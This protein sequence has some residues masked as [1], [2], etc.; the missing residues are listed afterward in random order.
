MQTIS[1]FDIRVALSTGSR[2]TLES[3][4]GSTL[5]SFKVLSGIDAGN[6]DLGME[7]HA[8]TLQTDRGQV[9]FEAD[10]C[11]ALNGFDVPNLVVASGFP[12]GNY[13]G[14]KVTEGSFEGVIGLVAVI[15]QSDAF[16]GPEMLGVQPT[17]IIYPAT[18]VLGVGSRMLIISAADD[19]SRICVST[20]ADFVARNRARVQSM[21]VIWSFATIVER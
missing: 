3:L 21:E 5:T 17:S 9:S 7:S 14:G 16:A 8:L 18:F 6:S 10:P 15:W 1:A 4:G 20:A 12:Q 13:E 11:T 2:S 19:M